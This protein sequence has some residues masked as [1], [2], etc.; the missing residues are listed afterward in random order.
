MNACHDLAY[1]DFGRIIA[2]ASAGTRLP[3][4]GSIELTFKCNLRC[5]HC[6]IPDFSGRDEMSTGEITRILDEVADAGCLWLLLTG[7]EVLTRQDFPAIY[8]HAKQRGFLVAVFSNGTL[9]DERVADLFAEWPPFSL[10]FTLYGMSDETYQRTTGFPGRYTRVRRA[11]ELALDRRLP[12]ALKAVAMD[13]LVDEIPGMQEYAAT[14]GVPFRYDPTIHGRLDGSPQPTLVRASPERA[15]R[16]DVDDPVRRAEWLEF[17]RGFVE[18][19]A[20]RDG[21]LMSCGAGVNSFHVDPR[22]RLLTCEALPI[23]GYDLRRGS[24]L[25]GWNGPLAALTRRAADSTN[26]CS[27]CD[28]RAMCDRCP[29][30]ATLET[31]S[32]DGWIP[33]YC[34]ITHRRAAVLEEESG[35][36]EKAAPL[37]AHADRVA[38]GWTPPGAILPRSPGPRGGCGAGGCATGCGSGAPSTKSMLQIEPPS[39][40]A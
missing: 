35:R 39:R 27:R 8:R 17:Y 9:F 16:F 14:I 10:E 19:P 15:V 20:P 21:R 29:A 38:A 3:L 13:L 7:G 33:W 23:N 32:P 2:R 34:E 1:S 31:G 28:L 25:E 18:R 26:V 40:A 30:T 37:R 11:I 36:P 4:S 24:F 6:Y 5:V 22:G 12:L